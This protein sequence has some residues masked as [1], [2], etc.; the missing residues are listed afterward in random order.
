[1][2]G[3]ARRSIAVSA[4]AVA[5]LACGG[6][7]G[8]SP[9]TP[10]AEVGTPSTPVRAVVDPGS[11]AVTLPFDA[12]WPTERDLSDL[13][14]ALNIAV[15]QCLAK[16]GI[17]YRAVRPPATPALSS[18]RKYGVWRLEDAR[19]Y[20]YQAPIPPGDGALP[21][22]DE[23]HAEQESKCRSAPET[24][25]LRIGF[26]Y[27]ADLLAQYRFMKLPPAVSMEQG[28]S[29]LADWHACLTKAGV[30]APPLPEA[31]SAVLWMSPE[32][33]RATE[34]DRFRAAVSDVEC[35]TEVKLVQRLA[36]VEANAQQ[37]VIEQHGTEMEAFRRTWLPMR[38]AAAQV[39]ATVRG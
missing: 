25:K 19:K 26:Y 33:E 37:A 14:Y 36:D 24:E 15:A 18:W 2:R 30:P 13:G 8:P 11:G 38:K 17:S 7:A 27:R 12:Y 34:E 4:L 1:M 16:Q 29:V 10:Y 20:G 23:E 9:G 32:L 28:R 5:A 6:C 3:E 21:E 35:K 39:I 31:D 22:L